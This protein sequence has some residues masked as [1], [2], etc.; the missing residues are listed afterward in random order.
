[1]KREYV[2][3]YGISS[4]NGE[5]LTGQV[6][7]ADYFEKAAG[8]CKYPKVLGNLIISE[9]FRLLP[10]E[11]VEIPISAEN[12][13]KIAD[14]MGGGVINSGTAK[15]LVSRLWEKDA[16]PV[17]IVE[18]EGL[19]QINDREQLTSVILEVIE[20]NPRSI[21]DFRK[22]KLQAVKA[23]MGQAMAKTAGRGNPALIQEILD[24]ELEKLK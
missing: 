9:A 11:S 16:D 4:Y 13:A 8:F 10:P 22:G 14:M 15:K 21:A 24:C 20:N 1:R 19:G 18:S 3:K 6:E 17:A 2:E 23:L 12:M 5:M 7:I